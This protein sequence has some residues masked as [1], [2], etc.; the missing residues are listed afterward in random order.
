MDEQIKFDKWDSNMIWTCKGYFTKND[1]TDISMHEMLMN[2]WTHRTGILREY[3]HEANIF[4]QLF[5]IS[6]KMGNIQLDHQLLSY[7]DRILNPY[8]RYT[9]RSEII[10]W[11]QPLIGQIQNTVMRDENGEDIFILTEKYPEYVIA[12]YGG[13]DHKEEDDD[14]T[15]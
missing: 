13:Y 10:Y 1:G 15:E 2:I 5:K 14:D 9:N 3:S 4:S 11:I 7:F 8:C 6:R 12:P